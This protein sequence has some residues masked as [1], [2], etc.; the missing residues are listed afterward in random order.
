M[1]CKYG[2]N[3]LNIKVNSYSEGVLRLTI[4]DLAMNIPEYVDRY[5]A[6]TWYDTVVNKK[7]EIKAA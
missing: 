6:D 1:R 2:L 3:P 4:T 7:E 5:K